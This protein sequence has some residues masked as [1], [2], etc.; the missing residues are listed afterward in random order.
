[1][2]D[3][4][5]THP[6]QCLDCKTKTSLLKNRIASSI[7]RSFSLHKLLLNFNVHISLIHLNLGIHFN[8]S[9]LVVWTDYNIFLGLQ[10]QQNMTSL[11]TQ[12]IKRINHFFQACFYG[13]K[14][15][16]DLRQTSCIYHHETHV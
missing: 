11:V 8:L 16:V 13:L 1:M 10:C 15:A 9:R 7:T 4:K 6:F 14:Y 2:T 3:K 12:C 5:A